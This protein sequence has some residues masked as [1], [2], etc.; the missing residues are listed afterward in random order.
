MPSL[1]TSDLK[2]SRKGLLGLLR[3]ARPGPAEVSVPVD[4]DD[5]HLTRLDP[6][7]MEELAQSWRVRG[8]QG[9]ATAEAIAHAFESVARRRRQAAS[10]RNRVIRAIRRMPA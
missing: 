2:W 8:E 10:T 4:A 3:A 5:L 7:R 6:A 9:D 1:T